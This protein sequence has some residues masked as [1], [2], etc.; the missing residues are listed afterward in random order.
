LEEPVEAKCRLA[1]HRSEMHKSW[2]RTAIKTA[3]EN[4]GGFYFENPVCLHM[5]SGN[6]VAV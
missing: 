1:V 2:Q 5:N 6:L 3:I 4:L